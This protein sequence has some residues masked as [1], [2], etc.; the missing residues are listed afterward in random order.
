MARRF[1]SDPIYLVFNRLL[2]PLCPSFFF[3]LEKFS[4]MILLKTLPGP[5]SWESSFSC[6]LI[7][8]IFGLFY[9]VLN[10]LDALG[11]ELFVLNFL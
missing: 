1:F 10:F 3:M 2:V 6:I 11:K 7:I 4:S 9:C 8:L 5:L